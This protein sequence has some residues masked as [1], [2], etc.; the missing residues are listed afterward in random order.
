MGRFKVGVEIIDLFSW[1]VS[2]RSHRRE[3]LVQIQRREHSVCDRAL[4]YSY[5]IVLPVER[6]WFESN[7]KPAPCL[8]EETCDMKFLL[9]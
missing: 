4:L 2:F 1:L 3:L 6:C 9:R 8:R 5:S 7:H